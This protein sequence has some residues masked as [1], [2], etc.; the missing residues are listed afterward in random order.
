MEMK[1]CS[2]GPSKGS[3]TTSLEGAVSEQNPVEKLSLPADGD[4]NSGN[5]DDNNL[6]TDTT[7]SFAKLERKC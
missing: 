7:G 6:R 3:N 4:E 5:L 1:S 2:D